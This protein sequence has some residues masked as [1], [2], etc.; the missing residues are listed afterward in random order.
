MSEVGSHFRRIIITYYDQCRVQLISISFDCFGPFHSAE[1]RKREEEKC[2][3][4]GAT[5]S[6]CVP[7]MGRRCFITAVG[8]S[9]MRPTNDDVD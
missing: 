8:V 5:E 4:V 6:E 1:E 9:S 2:L 3:V 7:G